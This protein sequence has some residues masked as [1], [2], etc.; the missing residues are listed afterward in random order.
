[1]SLGKRVQIFL[2][3]VL[4]NK[5]LIGNNMNISATDFFSQESINGGYKQFV[6]EQVDSMNLDE[7]K[8]I[9]TGSKDI[10]AF[11]MNLFQFAKESGKKFRTK[12][13]DGELYVGRME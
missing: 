3:Y 9:D 12:V 13:V 7:L 10:A 6:R 11:R 1:M 2:D 8:I 4:T 5:H